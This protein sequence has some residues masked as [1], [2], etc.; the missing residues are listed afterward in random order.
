M[1][2]VEVYFSFHP[3][4]KRTLWGR[5]GHVQAFGYTVD[6]T[7]FFLQPT[8]HRTHLA[9]TH[10][11]DEV[12]RLMAEEFAVA[13]LI[14]KTRH[15][16]ENRFPPLIPLNCVS[17]CGALVGIR[18]FTIR[19]LERKLLATGGTVIHESEDPQGRPGRGEGAGNR[20]PAGD[21][22]AAWGL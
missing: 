2:P 19:G 11:H 7:W 5:L 13:R 22:G 10:H 17:E 20:T 14:I 15:T 16:H 12:E 21:D 18:A 1:Q 8:A 4:H 6:E 3:P 9:I